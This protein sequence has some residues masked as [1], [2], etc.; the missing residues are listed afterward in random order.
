MFLSILNIGHLIHLKFIFLFHLRN[1]KSAI[2]EFI[3]TK[4]FLS[5]DVKKQDVL[6]FGKVI[7]LRN[8]YE[9]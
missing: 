2:I 3:K 9:V 8:H 5:P 7:C 1:G 4:Y 6:T